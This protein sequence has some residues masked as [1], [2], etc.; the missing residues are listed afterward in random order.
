MIFPMFDYR[1]TPCTINL[2]P[3][4]RDRPLH[5]VSQTLVKHGT[6][7]IN[8]SQKHRLFFFSDSMIDAG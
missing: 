5:Q 1:Y 7:K 3:M 8:L 4:A 2:P 6:A